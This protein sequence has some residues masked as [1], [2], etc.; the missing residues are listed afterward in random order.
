ML[1]LILTAVLAF[2][3][4]W[5]LGA[6]DVANSMGTS[7]GSKAVTLRQALIIAGVL[8]LSGALLF[9]RHVST[10]LMLDIVSPDLFAAQPQTL[11]IGMVAV[12]VTCGVWLQIATGLGLPVAS[13]HAVVGAIAG[14]GWVTVGMQAVDWQMLGLISLSWILTPIISGAIAAL[15]YSLIHRWI[16]TSCHPLQQLYDWIPWLSTGLISVFGVIVLPQVIDGLPLQ[17]MPLPHHSLLL[18]VGLSAI[19][20][21][22]L[23]NWQRLTQAI[24]TSDPALDSESTLGKPQSSSAKRAIEQTMAQFQLCSACLVAFAHGSNDVGNAIAPLAAIAYVI[25]NGVVPTQG[26]SIPLWIVL[27]G[28]CGIVFGLAIWGKAVITTVGEG[29]I[30]LQPSGGF[31]AELGAATTIL[32]ASQAGLPVSTSHAIVGGVV[33]I[34]LLQRMQARTLAKTQPHIQAH[35]I[36]FKTLIQIASAWIVTIPLSMAL[37]AGLC[38]IAII[39]WQH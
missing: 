31:C 9:G 25:Q 4:A 24:R 37:S 18:I 35:P 1:I 32:L 29:I 12:L 15:L 7:V 26:V 17:S 27:L 33:G 38:R 28:G 5:N 19:A 14:F 3:V 36:Q 20:I 21:L 2:Y 23:F 22:T 30:S 39:G 16:L 6:N 13:S 10:T 11:V 8:E 34:G